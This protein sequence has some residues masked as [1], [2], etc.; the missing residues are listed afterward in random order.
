MT[1]VA[2]QPTQEDTEVATLHIM[3]S[4]GDT[5]ISWNRNNPDEVGIARR[6]FEE[7][8]KIKKYFAY[9][10]KRDGTKGEQIRTFDPDAEKIICAPAPVGG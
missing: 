9:R 10:I 1:S 2:E 6:A 5:Q 8:T 3:D 7:A 4:T